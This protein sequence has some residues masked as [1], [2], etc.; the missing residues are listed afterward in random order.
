MVTKIFTI[1]Y[2]GGSAEDLLFTLEKHE[3][4]ALIDIRE[5]PLSRKPGLSK[6]ALEESVTRNGIK[7]C[8]E[9]ALGAPKPIREALKKSGDYRAYFL[10]FDAYLETQRDVLE[11]I[12]AN[13][14]GPVALMCF[15]RDPDFCHRK[16]V[17]RVLGEIVGIKP[18][19][20][21]VQRA[22][23]PSRQNLHSG[24]SLSAA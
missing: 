6:K 7:Y 22:P 2:E 9:R 16:S 21:G 8:H 18:Q 10:G 23:A 19:H 4:S 14:E 5:M 15:E 11:R 1:G 17:A 12:G 13:F 24:Q 3:V 20:L